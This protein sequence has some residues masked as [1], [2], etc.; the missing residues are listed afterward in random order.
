M[1]PQAAMRIL[2]LSDVYFPRINGLST[3]ILTLRRELRRS[4]HE[5]TLIAPDYGACGESGDLGPLYRIR[6][7]VVWCDPEDRMMSWRSLH[8]LTP[9]LVRT[10]FDLVHAT[11]PRF[12]VALGFRVRG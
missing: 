6:S 3:A 7:R 12:S 5:V 8:H 1:G 2:M 9:E 10:G 11:S 4:G